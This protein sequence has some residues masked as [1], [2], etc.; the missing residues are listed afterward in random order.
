MRK[1]IAI[2]PWLLASAAVITLTGCVSTSELESVRAQADQAL[3][4]ARR[5]EAAAEAA[6]RRADS[7][8][9]AAQEAKTCCATN[10]EKI[11][12]AMERGMGK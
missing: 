4:V 7:A 5:A 3:A 8:M 1:T 6:N 11:D 9:R 2:T 12:R 10:S